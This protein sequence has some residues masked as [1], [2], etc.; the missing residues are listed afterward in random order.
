MAKIESRIK[1]LNAEDEGF[2]ARWRREAQLVQ[3]GKGYGNIRNE[4]TEKP[5][6]QFPK[7]TNEQLG[8]ILRDAYRAAR[9]LGQTELAEKIKQAQKALGTRGTHYG[10]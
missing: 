7:A 6:K 5:R 8:E 2:L 10:R 4:I 9:K 1:E 3:M